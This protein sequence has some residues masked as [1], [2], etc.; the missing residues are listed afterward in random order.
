[1][2]KENLW[3]LIEA[4]RMSGGSAEHHAR[5]EMLDIALDEL[6]NMAKLS[7]E[8]VAWMCSDNDL[9]NRGYSRFI[10]ECAGD[11]N[12]PVFTKVQP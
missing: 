4:Y 12:I 10:D 3:N 7:A 8:P 6:Y 11:W 2:T 9:R 5:K 1:M